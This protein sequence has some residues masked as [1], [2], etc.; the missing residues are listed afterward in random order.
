MSKSK[1][2]FY[3]I[4]VGGIAAGVS[5]LLAAP[6]SGKDLRR[7]LRENSDTFKD[8]FNKLKSEGMAVKDQIK[9]IAEESKNVVPDVSN[10]LKVA[11]KE[12]QTGIELHKKNIENEIMSLEESIQTLE[13]TVAAK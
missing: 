11:V 2:L 13:N 7:S 9:R 3:G 12:W 8:T 6:S 5:T 4:L 10:D 1:A